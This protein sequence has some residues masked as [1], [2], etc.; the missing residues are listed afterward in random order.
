MRF[1][2]QFAMTQLT[3]KVTGYYFLFADS[4]LAPK[5]IASVHRP[6]SSPQFSAWIK[7]CL[8]A[9]SKKD[10]KSHCHKVPQPRSTTDA[11]YHSCMYQSK[12]ADTWVPAF[13]ST[14]FIEQSWPNYTD[15]DKQCY[16]HIRRRRMSRKGHI[17]Y[18]RHVLYRGRSYS[19]CLWC[20]Y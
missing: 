8:S 9:S 18:A 19:L 10:A 1:D 5:F 2:A 15:A 7:A 20:L 13:I 4:T 17:S 16:R 11:T 3:S 12:K 6:S 14:I